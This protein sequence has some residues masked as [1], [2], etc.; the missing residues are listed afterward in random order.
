[1]ESAGCGRIREK[2]RGRKNKRLRVGDE[3][4]KGYEIRTYTIR[5]KE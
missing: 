1:M 4:G 5:E 2:E 3:E